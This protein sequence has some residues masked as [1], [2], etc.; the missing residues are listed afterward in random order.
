MNAPF[1]FN[2]EVMLYNLMKQQ[3]SSL[4]PKYKKE[5]CNRF[6]NEGSCSYGVKCRFAHGFNDI[7]PSQPSQFSSA[8]YSQ[9][10]PQNSGMS[11]S[12]Q[13]RIRKFKRLPIFIS[14]EQEREENEST[15]SSSADSS[16]IV[17]LKDKS[18]GVLSSQEQE[19]NPV[20]KISKLSML[21]NGSKSGNRKKVQSS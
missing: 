7:I 16:I 15:G 21:L 10:L 2:T 18:N 11:S 17:E 14:L 3:Q 20:P 13:Y 1:P 9:R 8:E 5:L 12:D 19:S 6:M 4:D